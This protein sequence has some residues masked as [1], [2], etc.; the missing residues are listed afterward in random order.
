VRR[1]RLVT[2]PSRHDLPSK[3]FH[4]ELAI[5]GWPAGNLRVATKRFGT[6]RNARSPQRLDRECPHWRNAGFPFRPKAW[7]R[8]WMK[9][10][11]ITLRQSGARARP[12]C[13][14][15]A[16][17]EIRQPNGHGS[18]PQTGDAATVRPCGGNSSDAREAESPTEEDRP[19]H[20]RNL[21][22]LNSP[23]ENHTKRIR[24]AR[25]QGLT[26]I[27]QEKDI[28]VGP[29]ARLARKTPVPTMRT[30]V[31]QSAGRRTKQKPVSE[32]SRRS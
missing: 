13:S 2:C 17:P 7:K 28:E 9:S 24:K 12:R 32:A 5:S 22:E 23:M 8:G 6:K 20:P 26:A 11:R 18:P 29:K 31:P 10:S 25:R 15:N 14:H 21:P 4:N 1:V 27:S 16:S 3:R 19:D 30:R